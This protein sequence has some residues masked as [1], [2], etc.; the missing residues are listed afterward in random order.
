MI[1]IWWQSL[2]ESH[3]YFWINQHG[4]LLIN[5]KSVFV[6]TLAEWMIQWLTHQSS[7][8]F[9]PLVSESLWVNQL[10]EWFNDSFKDSPLFFS[11]MNRC[12]WMNCSAT[13]AKDICCSY[14]AGISMQHAKRLYF[15]IR[16]PKQLIFKFSLIFIFSGKHMSYN[17]THYK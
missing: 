5:N 10:N 13:R 6:S 8:A 1:H 12:I 2:V 14:A 9:W 16:L 15:T 11:W 7:H 17:T 3:Q 4:K